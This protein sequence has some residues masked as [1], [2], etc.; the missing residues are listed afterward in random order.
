MPL[1]RPLLGSEARIMLDQ[2]TQEF[3]VSAIMAFEN[4]ADEGRAYR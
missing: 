2:K 1:E 3:G 4:F